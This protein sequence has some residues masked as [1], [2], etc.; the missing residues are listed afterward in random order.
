[1]RAAAA[2]LSCLLFCLAASAGEQVYPSQS[3]GA[4]WTELAGLG[5]E[6]DAEALEL[7]DELIAAHLAYLSA[8]DAALDE[9]AGMKESDPRLSLA[10]ARVEYLLET[11][12]RL[13]DSTGEH[14]MF[15][16][17]TDS[18]KPT[19]ADA[20]PAVGLDTPDESDPDELDGLVYRSESGKRLLPTRI[21]GRMRL[22][23]SATADPFPLV[24][25][26]RAKPGVEEIVDGPIF[27][28]LIKARAAWLRA[29]TLERL[30]RT[31]EAGNE[32]AGLGL[33]RDWLLLGPLESESEAF[34][35]I[36]FD[37]EEVYESFDAEAGFQGKNG[38][39]DWRPVTS[40]DPL[41]R[42]YPRA[43]YRSEGLKSAIA[44]ALVHSRENRGAVI[45]FGSNAPAT[46]CV[47]HIMARRS[48]FS[49]MADPDQEA[50]NVWLRK[51]WN[52]VLIKTSSTAEGWEMAVRLTSLDGKPFPCH[53]ATP[54][55]G[56]IAEFLNE[57]KEASRRSLLERYY[58]PDRMADLGGVSI[59]SRWLV[60]SP[61]DARANFYLASFLA[62]KRM[63]EGPERFDR[64]L[65][66]RRAMELSNNNP[67]FALMAARSVE[68]GVEG[69]DR[70][71]NLR[72]VLLKTA[73]DQGSAAALVDIGRL[74][75][76]VMRQPRRADEYAEQ[77]LEVNPMS[78]RA[79]VL[80]YDVAMT[81]EWRALAG[82]LLD[83]L[84]KRH[85]AAGAARF[86]LGRA[87]LADGR[88]RRALMEFHA[89]LGMDADNLEA[90]DG[91]VVALGMLGQT[92]AAVDLLKSHTERFPYDSDV[93]L[94]LADL[95][96]TLGRDGEALAVI[97]SAL[98]MAPDDVAALAMRRDIYRETYA[99][100]RA[101]GDLEAA[102]RRRRL[103]QE[104]DFSP[105]K[106]PPPEG[107]EYLYFQIED[108]ME[109]NG[110]INRTVSFAL[111]IYTE[112][113][114]RALRHLGFWIEPNFESGSVTLLNLIR[115]NGEREAFTP[116][117]PS[118]GQGRSLKFNLPP[119]SV[120]M[121]VEAEVE[122]RRRRI[123]FLGDYFGQIAPM[124]QQAPIRLSRYMFTSPG[125]KRLYFKPANGAPEAMVVESR[126]G[127]EV[128]RIWEMGDVPGFTPEP[129]SVGQHQIMP[130]IQVSSFG[131]WNEFARWYWRLI[132]S[133]YHTPPELRALARKVG[134][135]EAIPLARLDRAAEW[136]AA[137]LGRRDW[138]F[139]PYAYRPI[140]ARAILS[141][142][143]G[144]GK[145]RTL[146][147]CLFAREYGLNAL[148]VLARL[149]DSRFAP[150]GADDLSLPLLEHFNH[151]LALVETDHG[152]DV[153][154]DAS[155]PY[156]PPGVMPS[157]LAGSPGMAIG[158]DGARAIVIP[159]DGVAGCVWSENADLVLDED[160]SV[161][162]EQKVSG[163]GTAA[164]TLRMRFRN[165]DTRQGMWTSFLASLGAVPT[166]A[167]ADFSEFSSTP[168]SA[169]FEGRARLRQMATMA[170]DRAIL[171]LPPL[172]GAVRQG[173]Q[174]FAFPLSL[175]DLARQG[176]REQ[177]LL[178]P[179]G[180][181]VT[182]GI[183]ITYPEEWRL[184][185]APVSFRHSRPF[186]AIGLAVDSTPGHLVLDFSFEMPGHVITA[187]DFPDFRDM[188]ALAKRW[189]Q[190]QLVWEKP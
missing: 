4:A 142:L 19:P 83:R 136:V 69:P 134:G 190:P 20:A 90:L 99:E 160:G 163:T 86:R 101:D 102:A 41:G 78:L 14:E 117:P 51:G 97:G 89:I 138:E 84:V 183:R 65:I 165:P 144:D 66:F 171:E 100:G 110:S 113:A 120:G 82:Q 33:I 172:P 63:M 95:Y 98:E 25:R 46:V 30:G 123:P 60:N 186:G 10:W 81:M 118:D 2:V 39:V 11:C 24:E 71:E 125:D 126:D 168:A 145:D 55:A 13:L 115:P 27:V 153:L 12:Y 94:K 141:R 173:A 58:Q 15:L 106:T 140:N 40:L 68:A 135:D 179:H 146:L 77:A 107:W 154:L 185:N 156:R 175:D 176:T 32:A 36:H 7:R 67:F 159:D 170:D 91:A 137:N 49:G 5:S 1:M 108:R 29:L 139:G 166:A 43:H 181:K 54:T 119:L 52:I 62:A 180:F 61:D 162:W 178:L 17:V 111:R 72:L 150:L 8:L 88:Y 73:A 76:D 31:A 75:L 184:A 48:R 50:F 44:V 130:C 127:Q 85:P 187:E 16:R 151:S 9:I 133:Q 124:T 96:R 182:R 21:A 28:P 109:R 128:T 121:A 114:A 22:I 56:N 45:R 155:N 147:L 6:L 167:Q 74:Y 174:G 129:G 131:N 177:D 112:R 116:P 132:G 92:S 42:L 3:V 53:V 105:P 37:L 143:S 157:Q 34:S 80:D 188:A 104:I 38:P 149:R 79:G 57:V 164:E 148:P 70:E 103:R 87:S 152:G 26:V 169:S 64:E 189:L 23:D 18:L 93:R 122:I 158:R 35:D 47:N 161:L 59:L